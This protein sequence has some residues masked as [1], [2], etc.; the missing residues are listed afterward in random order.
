MAYPIRRG[1]SG[2][3][4]VFETAVKPFHNP[5][6][7]WVKGCGGDVLNLQER[8]EVGPKCRCELCAFR[9]M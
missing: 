5:L 7:L 2:T 8:S 6:G 3:E 9:L 1:A 4:C